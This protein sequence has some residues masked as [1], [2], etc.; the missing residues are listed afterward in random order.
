MIFVTVGSTLMGFPRLIEALAALPGGQLSVQYGGA[1]PPAHAAEAV[2]FLSFEQVVER[3]EAADVV[4]CH[5]GV[6]SILCALRA[7]HTPVVVPRS[8]R[9]FETVDDHQ[10]ELARA[11]ADEGKVI[12]VFDEA[13]L[14]GAVA[15]VPPRNASVAAVEHRLPE[16]VR[17]AVHPRVS[18]QARVNSS[19]HVSVCI[20]TY[21][22]PQSLSRLLTALDAQ[23]TDGRFTYSIVV[24]DNDRLESARPL[25]SDFAATANIPVRYCVEPRQNIA[26]ARNEAVENAIGELVAFIDDDEE[27]APNWLIRLVEAI[28]S[29]G[30]DGVVGPV[31]PR[32]RT[33]PPDWIVRGRFFDSPALP[34]GTRLRW[35]QGRTGNALLRRRIFGDQSHRFLPECGRGGED[36]ELF[37]RLIADGMRFT[38]CDAAKVYAE[39]PAERCSR[40]YLLKRAL[41]RGRAPTN[42]GWPVLVSL[43][44]A[45]AYALALPLLLIFGQHV[46]MRYLIKECD[47]LG[48]IL[49]NLGRARMDRLLFDRLQVR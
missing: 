4:V 20:C 7:G 33:P 1:P 46:F 12:P 26:L 22:R 40:K 27:P 44:A 24:A 2:T 14:A 31:S 37:R 15:S 30:A 43:A 35:Q 16:A 32:F 25:V 19:V 48:R 42:R 39:V 3:M 23:A 18:T 17:A 45:P 13:T 9:L 8:R 21:R 5:A 29:S 6:G 11:L 28:E 36:V 47:H 34:T 10:M 41:L 38:W 49:A